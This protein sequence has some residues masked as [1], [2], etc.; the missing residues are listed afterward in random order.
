[1]LDI[2]E[3]KRRAA[4]RALEE[5]RDGM[6]LGLG[7]GSTARHFIAG[8]G[9]LVA[10]GMRLTAVATSRASAAQAAA[11]GVA[12]VES[13]DRPLDLT[14]D[15]ADEIDPALNLVKGLGGALLREKV[16]A[17]AS[18]RMVVIATA[19][20]LVEHLGRGPLP[21]EVLPL[22]W[23]RT[24]AGVEA[25]GLRPQRRMDASAAFV[26]D[27]GNFILDCRFDPPRDLAALAAALEAIPGVMGHGLFLGMAALALVAG[28]DGVREISP[29]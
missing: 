24:A 18:T 14:V 23:R 3:G 2:E 5:V 22:L 19:D 25:L 11:L 15:G 20:K 28:A 8:V 9:R 17:G 4:E 26:S 29:A 21:V 6:L 10:G 13:A 1:V 27:N 12:L 16:V 7:T